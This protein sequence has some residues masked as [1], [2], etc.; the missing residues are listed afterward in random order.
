VANQEACIALER[1]Q[2]RC[3]HQERVFIGRVRQGV[4]AAGDVFMDI[5]VL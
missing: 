3:R 5:I 1:F 4:F 2:E